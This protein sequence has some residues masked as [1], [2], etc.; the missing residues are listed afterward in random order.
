VFNYE[1]NTKSLFLT[2]GSD[3]SIFYDGYRM[4]S[5]GIIGSEVVDTIG[6]GDTFYAFSCLTHFLN[7]ENP[8]FIP[9]L[10]ASLSTTWRCNAEAVNK[11]NLSEHARKSFRNI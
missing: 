2:L 5:H 1:L 9:S 11:A 3:G 7:Y 6:A 4:L 10:A 8:L